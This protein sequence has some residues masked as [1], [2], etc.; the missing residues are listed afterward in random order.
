MVFVVFS[1]CDML[2]DMGTG[3]SPEQ[4]VKVK[5]GWLGGSWVAG[6]VTV[7]QNHPTGTRNLVYSLADCPLVLDLVA[8]R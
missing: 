1:T 5:K 4:N 7:T 3:T 8:W 2:R 6:T